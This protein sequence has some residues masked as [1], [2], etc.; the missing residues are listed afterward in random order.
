MPSRRR[1]SV[2]SCLAKASFCKLVSNNKR[3]DYKLVPNN[4]QVQFKLVPKIQVYRTITDPKSRV[5][6]V[7]AEQ[8]VGLY[9]CQAVMTLRNVLACF[10]CTA[11]GK[12]V[13]E[14]RPSKHEDMMVAAACLWLNDRWLPKSMIMVRLI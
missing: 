7:C 1:V 4:K 14:G 2:N 9:V 5:E 13:A 12:L 10:A 6:I 3:V 8:V 11:S